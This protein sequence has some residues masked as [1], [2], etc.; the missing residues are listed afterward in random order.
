MSNVTRLHMMHICKPPNHHI[1]WDKFCLRKIKLHFHQIYYG[2]NIWV[3]ALII[4]SWY[5]LSRPIHMLLN[6]LSK[7]AIDYIQ[8]VTTVTPMPLL[9]H[10]RNTALDIGC[11]S[12]HHLYPPP[13]TTGH[14]LF[15]AMDEDKGSSVFS[16]SHF[17]DLSRMDWFYTCS[18]RSWPTDGAVYLQKAS[19]CHQFL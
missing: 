11:V 3:F 5:A 4:L 7:V 10:C 14:F 13:S 1:L 8:Y 17:C 15:H 2:F 9:N 6:A 18:T 12:G 16:S 19:V